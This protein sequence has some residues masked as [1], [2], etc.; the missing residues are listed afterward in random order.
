[1]TTEKIA[2]HAV[3]IA[4]AMPPHVEHVRLVREALRIAHD[5]VIVLGS[6][7]C[8]R[9]PRNPFTWQERAAMFSLCLDDSER[10][11]LKFVPIRDYYNNDRWSA[12]VRRGVAHA[13][14]EINADEHIVLV[15]CYKDAG[16]DYLDLF[17]TW[18][19]H[20][21]TQTS[22]VCAT[23]VRDILFGAED[24]DV[25]LLATQ[26][27]LHRNVRN[28]LRAWTRRPEF[29]D[30]SEWNRLN[31][32]YSSKWGRGPHVAVDAIMEC[33]GQVAMI[34]RKDMPGR[35]QL[36]FPGGF[37]EPGEWIFDGVL[38]ETKEE[39]SYG[40]F[41]S[42]MRRH[43][44]SV[45]IFDAPWR[46]ERA[47]VI[48]HAHHFRLDLRRLPELRA[49]SDA[50]EAVWIPIGQLRECEG[51]FFADHFHIADETFHLTSADD[52]HQFM[53][54]HAALEM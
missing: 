54:A 12:A 45:K 26:D 17:P 42:E 24:L 29:T 13:L 10:S 23:T 3:V 7:F 1:M 35:G 50:K 36:A 18:L 49:S 53:T 27:A 47:R 34:R 41:A 52:A 32:G 11:R 21:V 19:D 14:S 39:T 2:S 4:R 22:A 16:N 28:Y 48:S 31:K 20:R 15:G 5:L 51:Q 37:L 43:L 6:A 38:R 30:L 9:S 44:V 33:H 46:D 40:P 8:A 25:A